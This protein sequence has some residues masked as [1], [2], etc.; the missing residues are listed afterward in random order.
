MKR[1]G[2]G[3]ALIFDAGSGAR[4]STTVTQTPCGPPFMSPAW[5]ALFRHALQEADRLGL[6]ISLN[7]GSGW[8]CGGPWVTPE[9]ASQGLVWSETIVTGPARLSTTLPIPPRVRTDLPGLPPYYRDVALLAVPQSSVKAEPPVRATASSEEASWAAANAVDGDL[10]T[11]WV[12]KPIA[13]ENPADGKHREW[14]QLEYPQPHRALALFIAAQ[15]GY[16]PYLGQ[17]Q[18]R[19]RDG[20]FAKLSD[21]VIAKN[22]PLTV[23]FPEVRSG[24]FRIWL[25]PDPTQMA[26]DA[27]HNI[28]RSASVGPRVRVAELL[29]DGREAI[30]RAVLRMR[31]WRVK[32]MNVLIRDVP[33]DVPA[34]APGE[35]PQ[36]ACVARSSVIDLSGR[37]DRDGRL[38]WQVPPGRWSILRFGRTPTGVKVSMH[39][40][41][42]AGLMLDHLSAEAMDLHF[43]NTAGK[44]LAE[45]GDLAGKS[46]KY[47]HCDSWELG[48]TNW[49]PRFLSEFRRRRGYD[50]LPYLPALAGKIVENREITDRFCYDFRRTVG[51]CIADNHY[52]RFRD[53]SHRHGVLFHPESGGGDQTAPLDALK[54]LGRADIPMGEFWGQGPRDLVDAEPIRF[55]ARWAASAAHLYGS[56]L[57]NAE[58]FTCLGP[59]WEEDPCQLKPLADCAFCE[60]ANRFFCHTFT[61]SPA[62]AGKPGYEY[63]AGTHFNPQITWWEQAGA[64]TRYIAR[65]AFLLQQGRFVADACYYYGDQVPNNVQRKPPDPSLGPG[66]GYDVTGAGIARVA[67]V[68]ATGGSCSPT[69]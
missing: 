69:A 16:G 58:A 55:L 68:G 45:A 17:L 20:R 18:C 21:F 31:N 62:A 11:L 41:G 64:W 52:G 23:A 35:F 33:A 22:E 14:L 3:G 32:A 4:Y 9:Y 1:K 47:F 28:H 50:P 24:T 60:G 53:L 42:G 65:A 63:Y 34:A 12:S 7:M 54:C 36:D 59:H 30:D 40:P 13:P 26:V 25:R 15:E 56:R 49:T 39:T 37:L 61:H 19:D 2:I 66:Y 67:N 10:A 46:L 44:L 5:R 29:L 48:L 8:D 57:V 51:D 27:I 43:A 6:E 38:D